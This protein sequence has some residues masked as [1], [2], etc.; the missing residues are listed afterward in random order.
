MAEDTYLSIWKITDS[1]SMRNR[2]TA[3]AAK[4]DIDTGPQLN[5]DQWTWDHR[6]EW[7]S[8]P[9]WGAA[10]EYAEASGNPDPGADPAVITDGMILSQV[11][12]MTAP[13]S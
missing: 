11:Q 4:E 13:A 8:A 10:F 3:C 2:V 9:G 1:A 12:S 6:W 5:F 7:A